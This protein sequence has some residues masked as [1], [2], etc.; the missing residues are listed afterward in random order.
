[1]CGSKF[2]PRGHATTWLKRSCSELDGY[3]SPTTFTMSS[4]FQVVPRRAPP[5]NLN[6]I[7]FSDLYSDLRPKI[8][9][10][11]SSQLCNPRPRTSS[12]GRG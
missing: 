6:V 8:I 12:A 11:Q 4:F 1:M 9:V 5:W 2:W 10:N 3:R 7:C